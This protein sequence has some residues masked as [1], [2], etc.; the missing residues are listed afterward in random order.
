MANQRQASKQAT[1]VKQAVEHKAAK[2]N[3]MEQQQESAGISQE[4]RH[5]LIEKAAYHLAEQRHFQG[6]REMD[7]WLQAE[8]AVDAQFAARH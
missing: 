7:D 1:I 5:R 8:A 6:D 3:T 2:K 4:K